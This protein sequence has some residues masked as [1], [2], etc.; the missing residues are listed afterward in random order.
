MTIYVCVIIL[1]KKSC[2]L[3]LIELTSFP[4]SKENER[5]ILEKK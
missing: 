4:S 2:K 5:L 3:F 1:V